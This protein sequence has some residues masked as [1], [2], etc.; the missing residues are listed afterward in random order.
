MSKYRISV[1]ESDLLGNLQSATAKNQLFEKIREIEQKYQSGRQFDDLYPESLGLEKIEFTPKTE[2]EMIAQ[3][4]S[5]LDRE[6][7][8]KLKDLQ[9]EYEQKRK[10]AETGKQQE[11]DSSQARME[12]LSARYGDAKKSLEDNALKRGLARS[13]VVMNELGALERER[14]AAAEEIASQR[15]SAVRDW[16]RTIAALQTAYEQAQADQKNDYAQDLKDAVDALRQ[17]QQKQASEV[18][19]YNNAVA[20][21]EAEYQMERAEKLAEKVEQDLKDPEGMQA[22]KAFEKAQAI[23]DY[24]DAMPKEAAL[25]LLKNDDDIRAA[26]GS[27][28]DYLYNYTKLR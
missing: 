22:R 9:S 5:A 23:R 17:E 28:Y 8:Q 15:D 2:E 4:S 14:N 1:S 12:E 27:Y 7:E 24:L 3:S 13:S 19:Q 16:D 25:A 21:K 26:A 6:Y 10:N 11:Y 20:E 18:R